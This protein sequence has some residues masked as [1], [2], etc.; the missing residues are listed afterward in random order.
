MQ[1]SSIIAAIAALVASN[2]L[3][4]APVTF[5]LDPSHTQVAV[6]WSHFGLSSPSAQ[7][8]GIEGTLVYDADAP[9]QSSVKVTLPISGLDA[10]G[11]DFNDHLRS[12]DFFESKKYAQATFVSTKVETAGAGKLRVTGNLT[13]KDRTRPVLLH[14]TVNK[15]GPHPMSQSLAAGFNA[16][17]TLKRSDFGLGLF[18]PGV[19]DEVKLT[20]TAEAIEAKPKAERKTTQETARKS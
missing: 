12:E 11:K 20:I 5:T 1:R 3:V 19:S 16:T 2:A 4:A 17:A 7:F 13:V 14:V 15:V 18:A 9:E 10:H 8:S 6:T